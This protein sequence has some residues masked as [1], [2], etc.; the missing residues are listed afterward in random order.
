M[1]S[2]ITCLLTFIQIMSI[3]SL[4][5]KYSKF[6]ANINSPYEQIYLMSVTL[7]GSMMHR[8]EHLP[9]IVALILGSWYW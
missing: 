5:H 2:L 3:V 1:G 8:A 9:T 4:L 6:V 7:H